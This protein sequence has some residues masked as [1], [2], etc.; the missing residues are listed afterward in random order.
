MTMPSYP[1][2]PPQVTEWHREGQVIIFVRQSNP[3][4]VRNNTGSGMAQLAQAQLLQAWGFRESQIV[5]LDDDTGRSGTTI[6]GRTGW[7]TMITGIVSDQVRVVVMT[8]VS[9]L[10][11]TNPE[12]AKFL[13][14]C[15]WKNVLLIDNGVPRDVRQVGDWTTVAISAVL[16]EQE[17]RQRTKRIRD[18]IEAK[19]QAGIWPRQL[20]PGF[21]RGPNGKAIKTA[22]PMVR[23]IVERVWREALQG[24]AATRIARDLRAEG[25]NLP[26]R[27]PRHTHRWVKPTAHGV[28]LILRNHLYAGQFLLWKHR[29]ERTPEGP[30]SRRTRPAEQRILAGKEVEAYVTPDEFQ[31]VQG[32]LASRNL[33][34]GAT[35]GLGKALCAQLLRCQACQRPLYVRYYCRGP[36]MYHHYQCSGPQSSDDLAGRCMWVNGGLL[37]REVEEI[38]LAEL[39][40]PS[41]ATLRR[42]IQAENARRQASARLLTAEVRQAEAEV[43][44]AR[45]RLEDSRQRGKNPRVTELYEDELNA[46]LERLQQAKERLAA[47]PP[48]P[49]LDTSAA[50][51]GKVASVFAQ[52]PRLWRSGRLSHEERKD[53]VRKV[54]ERIDVPERVDPM[55]L[56]VV[57]RSG[58]VVERYLF[59]DQ[60]RRQLVETLAAEGHDAEEIVT[61]LSRRRILNR[62]GRPFKASD[63]K[64][65]LGSHRPR[66]A[67]TWSAT[68]KTALDLLQALWGTMLP[69]GAIAEQLNTQGLRTDAGNVWTAFVVLRWAKRLNLP[70]RCQMVRD[71]LRGPLME[72]VEAGWNDAAIAEELTA[73]GVASYHKKPWTALRVRQ[74][75]RQLGIHRRSRG[76]PTAEL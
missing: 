72:L 5:V 61:E 53:V 42:A 19:L 67:H 66:R 75:R 55:R 40:C 9:R 36:Y 14:L 13:A 51:V 23:Q 69:Q 16:A 44:E 4:Q 1:P 22:D 11:R 62:C 68:K 24:K 76:I 3:Y 52:F 10:G 47:A 41:P 63:I 74:T 65:L 17:N 38:V 58:K 25:L 73:R 12:L 32:L 27:G 28:R 43:A 34:T 54:V 2:A 30:V 31:C 26:V 57:L 49:F 37:D 46:K 7:A 8:E 29:R 64:R 6:Q 39:Q 21:D 18:A 60:S 20:P 15:E 71:T 59:S 33:R 56:L 50:F 45:A 35:V 48:V 70:R